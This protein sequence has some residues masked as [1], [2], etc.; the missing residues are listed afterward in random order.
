[1]TLAQLRLVM[2]KVSEKRAASHGV[3]LLRTMTEFELTTNA[4]QAAFVAQVAHESGELRWYTE[5]WGP[6]EWQ[7]K[8]EGHKQLGNVFPGDGYRFRGRGAIQ[9]TG[10]YNYE[11][12][13]KMLGVD[14]IGHPT[15]AAEPP[16]GARVAGAFFAK[17]KL[18]ELAEEKSEQ[19]LRK[20]TKV[21]NPG[22]LGWTERLMYYRRALE[23]LGEETL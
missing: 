20:I 21:I 23:V 3:W 7:K 16:T 10:R 2:P 12:A 17:N 6:T 15:M 5:L 22:M 1:M 18:V 9:I 19:A 8:Y 4:Q 11:W 14:L 13:G